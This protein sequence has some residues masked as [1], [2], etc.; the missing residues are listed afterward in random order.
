LNIRKTRWANCSVEV[1]EGVIF[2]NVV[3]GNSSE[4]LMMVSIKEKEEKVRRQA[5]HLEKGFFLRRKNW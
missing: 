3:D 4:A 1:T 5:R 2:V